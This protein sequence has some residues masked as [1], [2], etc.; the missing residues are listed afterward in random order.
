MYLPQQLAQ[1][2]RGL[3]HPLPKLLEDHRLPNVVVRVAAAAHASSHAPLLEQRALH[4]RRALPLP[5]SGRTRIGIAVE[6]EHTVEIP[7]SSGGRDAGGRVALDVLR[8]VVLLALG[9]F[10]RHQSRLEHAIGTEEGDDG[11][12]SLLVEDFS[13]VEDAGGGRLG[14]PVA[15]ASSSSAAEVG[16]YEVALGATVLSGAQGAA[17]ADVAASH[18]IVRPTVIDPNLIL[19]QLLEISAILIRTIELSASHRCQLG[20]G[21]E[22]SSSS[23]VGSINAPLIREHLHLAAQI[24]TLELDARE[25]GGIPDLVAGEDRVADAVALFPIG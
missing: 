24:G 8:G 17:P 2:T 25:V 3:H 6:G 20:N 5:S 14:V 9:D 4:L 22:P 12:G 21:I 18:A 11:R 19:P 1:L 10:R 16:L 15:S 23:S 13:A 7:R